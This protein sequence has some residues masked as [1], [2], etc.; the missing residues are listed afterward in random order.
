MSVWT[1]LE[2]ISQNT[3]KEVCRRNP[4]ATDKWGHWRH[5]CWGVRTLIYTAGLTVGYLQREYLPSV[6][7]RCWLGVM[8][9][10][11]TVKIDWWGAGVVVC[12][13]RGAFCIRSTWLHCP[14]IVSAVKI[15]IGSTFM[16]PAYPGRTEK[17]AVKRVYVC[18]SVCL[19]VSQRSDADKQL[20][21]VW[22]F[23]CVV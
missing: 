3:C 23:F 22:S 21:L 11:R 2:R 4:R 14:S 18:L 12:L 17:E 8:K 15:Q 1:G 10:I 20:P 7:W 5:Y 16:A 6:L 13:E 19:S 9:S